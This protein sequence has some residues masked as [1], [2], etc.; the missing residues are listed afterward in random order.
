MNPPESNPPPANTPAAQLRIDR[1][2]DGETWFRFSGRMDADSVASVWSDA[3]KGLATSNTRSIR[4]DASEVSYCDGA[5][6]AMLVDL[7][8]RSPP[9]RPAIQIEGLKDDFKKLMD[10][11]DI[12]DFNTIKQERP[13]TSHL[14]EQVGQ[15]ASQLVRDLYELVVFLGEFTTALFTVLRRPRRLRWRDALLDRAQRFVSHGPFPHEPNRRRLPTRR[16]GHRTPG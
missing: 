6:I 13:V 1:S 3:R 11:F 4:L 10:L 5:G 7:L 14:P 2:P 8:R 16:S 9:N 12:S 15:A